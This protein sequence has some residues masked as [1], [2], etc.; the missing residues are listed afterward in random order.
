MKLDDRNGDDL[1][2]ERHGLH[3]KDR[4]RHWSVSNTMEGLIFQR[5]LE[6]TGIE[7]DP[8]NARL[9]S[10]VTWYTVFPLQR[11]PSFKCS[12]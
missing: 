6:S 3:R 4:D 11:A 5:A 10:V 12:P 8:M 7:S 2:F 1:G 9:F